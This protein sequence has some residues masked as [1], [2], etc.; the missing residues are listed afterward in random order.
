MSS[1]EASLPGLMLFYSLK[2]YSLGSLTRIYPPIEL[3]TEHIMT[4]IH[5]WYHRV[6]S[7][8]VSA[9]RV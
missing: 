2:N 5:W 1:I 8:G 7:I 4:G 9:V 3:F 6:K